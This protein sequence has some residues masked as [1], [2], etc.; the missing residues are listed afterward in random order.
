LIEG[1]SISLPVILGDMDN[2][3]N[4]VYG[5]AFTLEY[6]SAVVVPGSAKMTFNNGWIGSKGVDMITIQKTFDSPG[7][8]DV[9]MTRIDGAEM[10][11]FGEIG[12]VSITIEDD[13]LFRGEDDDNRNGNA[14][15]VYFNI[16][17]VRIINSLGEEIA[18]NTIETSAIV[19]GTVGVKSIHWKEYIQIQPNPAKDQF[20]VTSKNI[21][22]TNLG[23][24]AITGELLISQTPENF[25]TVVNT[26]NLMPGIYLLK[27]QTELG[28]MVERIVIAK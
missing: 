3:A 7:V 18:V 15:E 21:D 11:G 19:D 4:D 22:I 13:I 5:L 6:D 17:N 9:G 16:S 24:F 23:L 20:F 26:Q 10:D 1:E 25:E 8:V 28:I 14:L 12:Q 27:V 2:P